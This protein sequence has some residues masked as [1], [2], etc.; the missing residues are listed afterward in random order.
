[1]VRLWLLC[2]LSVGDAPH[3]PPSPS[4]RPSQSSLTR[5]LRRSGMPALSSVLTHLEF[6]AVPAAPGERLRGDG[7][8]GAAGDS[9]GLGK[10]ATWGMTLLDLLRRAVC[11]CSWA[12]A[13]FPEKGPDSPLPSPSRGLSPVFRPAEGMV[14]SPRHGQN[15]R[16]GGSSAFLDPKS[17]KRVLGPVL[18]SRRPVW[19]YLRVR[20]EPFCGCPDVQAGPVGLDPS[21]TLGAPVAAGGFGDATSRRSS[22]RCRTRGTGSRSP[23]LAVPTAALRSQGRIPLSGSPLPAATPLLRLRTP[24]PASGGGSGN[25]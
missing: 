3:S 11:P 8:G 22:H 4:S 9:P 18:P 10:K 13:P 1:M 15:T 19:W 25:E 23:D 6:A 2:F 12:W 21:P 5:I 16:F 14:R 17:V 7:G 20:P 24:T